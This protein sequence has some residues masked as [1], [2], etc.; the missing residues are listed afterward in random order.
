MYLKRASQGNLGAAWPWKR[1]LDRLAIAG[2]RATVRSSI[3]PERRPAPLRPA[4]ATGDARHVPETRDVVILEGART[5]FCRAGTILADV[6]AV[7]LGRSARPRGDRAVGD[8]AGRDR[9]GPRR[10]HRGA[11]RR[12]ERR[13]GD[14]PRGAGVPRSVPAATVNR[15]CGSALQAIADAALKI[16]AGEADVVVAAGVESMSRSRSSIRNPSSGSSRARRGAKSAGKRLAAFAALRPRDFKPVI[17]LETGL[18]DPISGLNM[19]ETAEVLAARVPRDARG[20]GRPGAGEPPARGACVVGRPPRRRG[21]PLPLPPRYETLAEKDNGVRENQSLE[22]LAKLKP[23]FD[24]EYGTVTAGNSS[25]ITDGGAAV[26]LASEERARARR[27]SDPG[28]R[29][30]PSPSR[31]AIRSAWGWDPSSRRRSRSPARA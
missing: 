25:Q 4:A 3:M 5:P 23:W 1:A 15:N 2:F 8:R 20:A 19:G 24:R 7:E 31:P 26:V 9:R 28:T 13:A 12:R 21:R 11:A 17:A 6:D 10:Q 14:R 16:R 18:T 27:G 22:A 30:V 29:S